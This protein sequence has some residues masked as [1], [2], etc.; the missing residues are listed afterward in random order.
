MTDIHDMIG[1]LTSGRT[2]RQAYQR[3]DETHHHRTYGGRA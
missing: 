3:G 2:N 1:E